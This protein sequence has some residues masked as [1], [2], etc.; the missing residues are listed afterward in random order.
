MNL[1]KICLAILLYLE[2]LNFEILKFYRR[3]KASKREKRGVWSGEA[4]GWEIEE[5][6]KKA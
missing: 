3:R 4:A 1:S 5:G 2:S 6:G